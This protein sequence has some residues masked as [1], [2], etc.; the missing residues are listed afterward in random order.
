MF[1]ASRL[2]RG[3]LGPCSDTLGEPYSRGMDGGIA[4]TE[5]LGK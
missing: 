2:L 4:V 3:D 5:Q 1:K